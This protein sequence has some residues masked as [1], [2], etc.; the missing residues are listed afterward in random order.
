MISVVVYGR[1]DQHGYNMHKRVATSLNAIAELLRGDDEIIFVDYAT[2]N[3]LPTLPEAIADTLSGN[4]RSFLR[5]IRVRP[6]VHARHV[7]D[8]SHLPISEP[9]ARNAGIR[10]ARNSSRWILNTNTDM[11]LVP[12]SSEDGSLASAVEGR[13]EKLFGLPRYEIPEWLWERLDR[14]SP[15]EN[16]DLIAEWGP[17]LCLDE[18]MESHPWIGYDAPG[19]FQLVSRDVMEGVNG[20]DER[21]IH[22]WHVDSNLSRRLWLDGHRVVGLESE[23]SGYHMNHNRVPTLLASSRSKENSIEHFYYGVTEAIPPGQEHWGLAAE[24][25]EEIRLTQS[26]L[27]TLLAS[28]EAQ[29]PTRTHEPEV[30]VATDQSRRLTYDLR[31]VL[32]FVLDSFDTLSPGATV[33]YVGESEATKTALRNVV[34]RMELRFAEWSTTYVGRIDLIVLDCGVPSTHELADSEPE[35]VLRDL[36]GRLLELSATGV[37]LPSALNF[38]VINGY[39]TPLTPILDTFLVQAPTSVSANVGAARL[40]DKQKTTEHE[41]KTILSD[42]EWTLRDRSKPAVGVVS[43]ALTNE[44]SFV[45]PLRPE[46]WGEGWAAPDPHGVRMDADRATVTLARSNSI[47]EEIVVGVD[48]V[49]SPTIDRSSVVNANVS[50][51]GKRVWSGDLDGARGVERFVCGPVGT[52]DLTPGLAEHVIEFE[53][54]SLTWRG[55]GADE[56]RDGPFLRLVELS[57]RRGGGHDFPVGSVQAVT[58]AENSA[59]LD[60]GRGWDVI[61]PDGVWMRLSRSDFRI[62]LGSERFDAVRLQVAVVE[63]RP[64]G[65]SCSI[66]VG[67]GLETSFS[68]QRGENVLSVDVAELDD[69]PAHLDVTVRVPSLVSPLDLGMGEDDRN[70]GVFLRSVGVFDLSKS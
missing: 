26:R 32:P 33:C 37:N 3:S 69:A 60:L 28:A 46:G 49:A 24:E 23:L 70:L 31:H 58:D 64:E 17:K 14:R 15:L 40:K 35:A 8:R 12:Q 10:R 44:T 7:G 25:L 27:R 43:G 39:G 48:W 47:G 30:R 62:R 6:E 59:G 65:G 55:A 22:G 56:N 36:P 13:S 68:L 42:L 54:E 57:T 52:V 11:I 34:E 61:E 38:C 16:I 66:A 67:G 1:N 18:S 20:F 4:C 51:D 53:A 2:P 21:M 41:L 19:D 45:P 5:V 50:V 29:P 63:I 9:H